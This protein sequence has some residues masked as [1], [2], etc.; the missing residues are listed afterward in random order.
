MVY[1]TGHTFSNRIAN[2]TAKAYSNCGSVQLFVNGVSQGSTVSSSNTFLWPV[3]LANGTNNVSAIGTL[4]STTVTD[5]LVWIVGRHGPPPPAAPTSL[6]ATGGNAVVNLT[7]V[8]SASPGI[9]TNN[10]YRSTTGSGGPYGLLA[11]LAATTSYADTAVVNGS[12]YFYSVTA[13]STNGES[14]MSGSAGA[15][16]FAA[17]PA[18]PTSLVATGGNAVVNLTW[19]QS[20]PPP[21]PTWSAVSRQTG[22]RLQ[23]P[24]GQ[25]S[26]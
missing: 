7:W 18:A 5:S 16:P 24:D 9:T 2:I 21:P 26:Y 11:S 19:V 1:I 3:T 12:N 17:P 14:A 25:R 8:Q 13:V 22:H 15:T 6:V 20:A 4:G 23:L 10:V